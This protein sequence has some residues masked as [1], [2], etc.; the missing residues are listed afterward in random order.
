ME[1][2]STDNHT[3]TQSTSSPYGDKSG[4][5]VEGSS[6]KN[7]NQLLIPEGYSKLVL[8]ETLRSRFIQRLAFGGKKAIATKI[9]DESLDILAAKCQ[10]LQTHSVSTIPKASNNSKQ[11]TSGGL[12]SSLRK[13]SDKIP[14]ATNT[15]TPHELTSRTKS[16]LFLTALHRSKPWLTTKTYKRGGKSVVIPEMLNSAQQ[17]SM[18]IRW[19]VQN[20]QVK[21]GT[22]G[23]S[24]G[25]K[26]TAHKLADELFG[27]LT[28]R[29]K[30]MAQREQIHKLA[31]ANRA[32]IL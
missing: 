3:I 11:S 5:P 18:S 16:D 32:W 23:Y 6:Q 24:G 8:F 28:N 4:F 29:G 12:T 30:T 14:E 20:S 10:L 1:S 17:E 19:L 27:C 22:K 15:D 9:F 2:L 13:T 21:T 26:P 31:E 25:M 7:S